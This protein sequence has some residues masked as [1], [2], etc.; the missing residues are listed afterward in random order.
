MP[1]P[2]SDE[3]CGFGGTFSLKNSDVSAA[4]MS[5]KMANV[6]STGAEILVAGDYSC[7]M[8]IAGG[9]S[10]TRAGI[11]AI[12]LAEVLAGTRAEPWTAPATNTKVGA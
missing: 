8:S 10:R 12:H 3:C 4:M 6:K 9:L 2:D 5:D 11:R 1:L 7:L